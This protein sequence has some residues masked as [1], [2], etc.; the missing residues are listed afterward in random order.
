[1]KTKKKKKGSSRTKVTV[2]RSSEPVTG[3]TK[4]HSLQL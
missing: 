4:A 1:M 3:M 2:L